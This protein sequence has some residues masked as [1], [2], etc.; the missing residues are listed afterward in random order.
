MSDS[1]APYAVYPKATSP[2]RRFVD[3]LRTAENAAAGVTPFARA[4]LHTL[5]SAGTTA[6]LSATLGGI[7]G[8]WGL[9]VG[10]TKSVPIDGCLALAGA[11]ASLILARDPDGLGIEARTTMSVAGG[12]F[13]YRK[14]KA[15]AELKASPHYRERGSSNDNAH[16]PVMEA[17][18]SLEDAAAQ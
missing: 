4:G 14:T 3:S 13:L 1:L 11:A 12:I 8:R 7:D 16:D 2:L 6:V 17:A 5:R 10:K 15:W 18:G 9:D